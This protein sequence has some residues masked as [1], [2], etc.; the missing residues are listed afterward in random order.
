MTVNFQQSQDTLF[1]LASDTGGKALLDYNDL[2][3]GIRQAEQ[4]VSSYYILGYYTTNSAQDGKFRRIHISLASDPTATLDYRQG[5]YAGK[6]FA[7]FNAADKER[8]LEDALMLSDPITE[9]TI[10]MEIDYFQLNRAEYFVPHR[11]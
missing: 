2:T 11:G 1:T 9:L 4:S 3:R 8:Q 7:K 6:V 5:Y 10:A